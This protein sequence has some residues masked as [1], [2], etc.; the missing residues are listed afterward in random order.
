[1]PIAMVYNQPEDAVEELRYLEARH[2]PVSWVEMGEEIDGQ[3]MSPEDNAALYI[4]FA[5][6]LHKF[7]PKL[8]L[9]GPAFQGS[10]EDIVTWADAEGRTSWLTRFL[11]YLKAHDA[12]NEMSFFSFEHYPLDPCRFSWNALYDEPKTVAHILQVWKTDGV[13]AGMPVFITESN[14]SAGASEAYYDN[15]AGL[16]LADYVGSFLASGGDGLYLFHYLPLKSYHG[17]KNSPG[18]FGMFRV[19]DNYKIVQPLAQYFASQMLIGEWLMPGDG[20]HTI[21]PAS[22]TLDDG[23]GH[24]LVTAYAAERPD[25]QWSVLLVNRDQEN[26]HDVRVVFQNGAASAELGFVG[27][28]QASVFGS[29]QYQWHASGIL[30]MSHPDTAAE[31]AYSD[32]PIEGYAEPDGPLVRTTLHAATNGTFTIPPASIL[33]LKGTISAS[34]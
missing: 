27:D 16:W 25:K 4:Q 10:N 23:A 5:R 3:Y 17:C 18:T 30:P 6:A 20:V 32:K 24:M 29:G 1:M 2:Y 14:L 19:D 8:K 11:A 28:V 26:A 7:D 33:V 21:H 15:F 34:K 9:G 22:A 31:S 13:P 12:M